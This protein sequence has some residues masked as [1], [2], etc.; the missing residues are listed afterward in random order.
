MK[1]TIGA[2]IGFTFSVIGLWESPSSAH[3]EVHLAG[4]ILGATFGWK[5][6]QDFFFDFTPKILLILDLVSDGYVVWVNH[7]SGNPDI[8]M[9]LVIIIVVPYIILGIAVAPMY[10]T[11]FAHDDSNKLALFEYKQAVIFKKRQVTRLL[12]VSY[13]PLMLILADLCMAAE[14]IIS[15][16]LL[17]VPVAIIN[18]FPKS[19][20]SEESMHRMEK[21]AEQY[22]H[23][24]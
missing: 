15:F 24:R 13:T 14:T 5:E 8:V 9:L 10:P 3:M 16:L 2:L 23:L 20:A 6:L 19:T 4:I 7:I 21:Q 1:I 17:F 12:A 18:K 11:I 22:S